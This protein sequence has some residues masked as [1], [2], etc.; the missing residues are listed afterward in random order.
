MTSEKDAQRRLTPLRGIGASHLEKE[1]SSKLP[2]ARIK[3]RGQLPEVLVRERGVGVL[4]L[5]VVEGVVGFKP[6]LDSRALS[7]GERE[8]LE[9]GQVPVEEART[10]N[11]VLACIAKALIRSTRPRGDRG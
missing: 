8:F 10:H 1:L 4:E 5:R 2:G 11:G 9:Q 6:E 3:R 7:R